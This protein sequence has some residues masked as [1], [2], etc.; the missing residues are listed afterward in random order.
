[1]SSRALQLAARGCRLFADDRLLVGPLD[2]GAPGPATGMALGLTPRVRLPPHPAAGQAF[3]DFLA[4][5]AVPAGG[6]VGM[7]PLPADIAAGFAEAAPIGALFLPERREVGGIE[8]QPAGT[9][10]ASRAILEQMHAPHMAAAEFISAVGRLVGGL[11]AWH[12]RY[13]DSA[14]AAAQV[15]AALRE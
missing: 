4:R 8:L 15:M 10:A 12:L 7:L 1:M 14:A 2:A 11:P 13:D 5:H 9:A 3:A 6:D